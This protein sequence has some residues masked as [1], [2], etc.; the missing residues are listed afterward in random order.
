MDFYKIREETSKDGSLKISPGF[1]VIRSKDLMVLGK[2]FYAIWD[3]AN[4]LWS[5]DEY[6]VQRLVDE[7]LLAYAEERKKTFDGPIK[8][9]LMR[10]FSSNSWK[11]FRS[12]LK[13][14]SDSAKQLDEN[15]TFANT[16]V[17]KTDYVTRRLTY[18]L[19]SGDCPAWDELV[20]TLYSPE[21]RAKIE[22]SIG[23][24]I[25]G[26]AKFIQKFNFLF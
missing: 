7:E 17:K 10:N 20:G 18:P 16:E 9:H 25:A 24:I 14:L 4:G 13:H 21:E 2:S 23:S 15:L 6:D 26:D 3:E 11:D 19:E 8:V 22:W 5:T 1:N 12:F